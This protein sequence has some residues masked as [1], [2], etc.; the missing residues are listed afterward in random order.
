M[1]RGTTTIALIG[2]L[3]IPSLSSCSLRAQGPDLVAESLG[4]VRSKGS[5]PIWQEPGANAVQMLKKQAKVLRPG[6]LLVGHPDLE[7]GTSFVI[8]QARRLLATN[9]HVADVI[10]QTGAMRAVADEKG[11]VVFV[12][13]PGREAGQMRAVLNGTATSYRVERI[14]FHPGVCRVPFV[15]GIPIVAAQNPAVGVVEL[16]SPDVAVLELAEGGPELPV[17]LTL[18]S[19]AEIS[20]LLNQAILMIGFPEA[21]G[22]FWPTEDRAV[23]SIDRIGVVLRVTDFILNAVADPADLQLLQH[24]AASWNGFSGSPLI[25][26]NGHVAGIH[27]SR[28]RA[29]ESKRQSAYGI[30]IDCLWELLRFHGLDNFVAISAD[31]YSIRLDRHLKVFPGLENVVQAFDLIGENLSENNPVKAIERCDRALKL[32]PQVGM[33]YGNRS[34]WDEYYRFSVI[35]RDRET[36]QRL[37][38]RSLTDAI[39][40]IQKDPS[41]PWAYRI[42]LSHL[43]T[44][45]S[46]NEDKVIMEKARGLANGI[47]H[48]LNFK[49]LPAEYKADIYQSRALSHEVLGALVEARKDLDEAIRLMPDEPRFYRSRARILGRQGRS[50]LADEDKRTAEQKASAERDHGR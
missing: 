32:A 18:A 50:D 22:P 42:E 34:I 24:T 5:L 8:S 49:Y 26:P 19:W 16:N 25:L 11:R 35:P 12:A 10:R 31:G 20:D 2:L 6:I 36:D 30:R 43:A 21:E 7:R 29:L 15:R 39:A 13:D 44:F 1:A 47:L 9:A 45:G 23:P 14:Y 33:I 46:I 27:N 28:Q 17:E 48:N 3:V 41:N 40:F 4:L 37:F 38:N